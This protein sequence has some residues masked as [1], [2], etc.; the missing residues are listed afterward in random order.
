[1]LK[2]KE[3]WNSIPVYVKKLKTYKYFSLM[4]ISIIIKSG[5]YKLKPYKKK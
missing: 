4:I 5:H 3:I 1:M 2:V